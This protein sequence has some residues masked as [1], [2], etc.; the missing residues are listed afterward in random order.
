[1]SMSAG[2]QGL[3]PFQDRALEFTQITCD[4]TRHG[5]KYTRGEEWKHSMENGK[6]PGAQRQGRDNSVQ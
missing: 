6:R 3:L 5:L 4:V 2:R 1:M